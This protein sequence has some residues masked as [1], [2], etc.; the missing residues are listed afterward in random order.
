[1]YLNHPLIRN[2]FILR[3]CKISKRDHQNQSRRDGDKPKKFIPM[4]PFQHGVLQPQFIRCTGKVHAKPPRQQLS[5]DHTRGGH[6]QL[7]CLRSRKWS[8][9]ALNS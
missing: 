3:S 1:M 8:N 9:D 4:L 6:R 5:R 2:V 7:S